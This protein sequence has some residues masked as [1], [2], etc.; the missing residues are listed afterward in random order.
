MKSITEYNEKKHQ[1][2]FNDLPQEVRKNTIEFFK[3]SNKMLEELFA[4]HN[5]K[6]KL[7]SDLLL[8][9]SFIQK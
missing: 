7:E 4:E 2:T 1:K 5:N 8:R 6:D 9:R 3:K